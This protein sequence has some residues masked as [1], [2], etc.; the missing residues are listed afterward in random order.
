MIISA[1]LVLTG[2]LIVSVFLAWRERE[3]IQQRQEIL[4][5]EIDLITAQLNTITEKNK[6]EMLKKLDDVEI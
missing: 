2:V 1:I 4:A 5:K 6:A 3:N